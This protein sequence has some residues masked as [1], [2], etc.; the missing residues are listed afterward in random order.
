MLCCALTPP[1]QFR[2]DS[3]GTRHKRESTALA[4]LL[5]AAEQDDAE[6]TLS[7]G[8][9]MRH[10]PERAAEYL[11][12]A[13]EMGYPQAQFDLGTHRRHVMC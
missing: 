10:N 5:A 13:A 2:D 1:L 3:I 6:A 12:R 9:L 8:R 7:A 11:V 4:F